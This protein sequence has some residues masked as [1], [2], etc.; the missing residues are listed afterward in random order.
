ME[1]TDLDASALRIAGRVDAWRQL[2]SRYDA[3]ADIPVR[4]GELAAKR[5]VTADILLRLGREGEADPRKLLL[6]AL[7]VGALEVLIA[8]R[9][10][11]LSKLET[12]GEAAEAAQSAYARRC[13]AASAH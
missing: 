5:D 12:T 2:R 8:V 13:G 9:S 7:V 4:R 10:G 6:S 1:R 3:A 11:V